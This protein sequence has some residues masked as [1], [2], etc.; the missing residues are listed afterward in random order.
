MTT[1]KDNRS[2]TGSIGLRLGEL[3]QMLSF[4]DAQGPRLLM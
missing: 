2:R 4:E 3:I 1:R